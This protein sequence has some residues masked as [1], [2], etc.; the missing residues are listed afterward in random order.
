M[1]IRHLSEA[2]TDIA[3]DLIRT[4]DA[5]AHLRGVDA[6]IAYLSSDLEKK[7]NRKVVY[8][9]CEKVPDRFKWSVPFDFTIT[10]FEPNVERFTDEQIRIL[11]F[12]ELLHVGIDLDG[13]EE[14]YY[15]VPHDIED[16]RKIINEY[17]L[18]WS[19]GE[20]EKADQAGKAERTR[21]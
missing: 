20:A 17:G 9:Q 15:I 12:H 2:Y 16:F 14:Q 11:L 4:E 7:S 10:V 21:S 5:L 1:E 19:H 6:Q 18:D 8:A 3:Q 13:N